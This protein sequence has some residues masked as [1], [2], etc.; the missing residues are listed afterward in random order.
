MP[1][2]FT[3]ALFFNANIKKFIYQNGETYIH[4]TNFDQL[5]KGVGYTTL[6]LSTGYLTYR[7]WTDS[8]AL[9]RDIFAYY[10]VG[11]VITNY[12]IAYKLQK[13]ASSKHHEYCGIQFHK[14]AMTNG[15]V[16]VKIGQHLA[17]M[18]HVIPDEIVSR[19]KPLQADCT[20]RSVEEVLQVMREE[21][22]AER[23]SRFTEFNAIPEGTASIAQVHKATLDG[24]LVA[25][26]I[27][28]R[29]ISSN[30]A[31][32][33]KLLTKLSDVSKVIFGKQFNFQWLVDEVRELLDT[34]L[35]FR[36]EASNATEARQNHA[37][38]PWLVIP[39]IHQEYTTRRILVLNY[40]SGHPIDDPDWYKEND[41][42][43][44][45]VLNKLSYLFSEMTFVTGFLHSDPHP[46]NLKIRKMGPIGPWQIVLLDHGQYRRLN[47]IF[48]NDY[49]HFLYAM[50][51]GNKPNVIKYGKRLNLKDPTA[52]SYLGCMM[53]GVKWE[54]VQGGGLMVKGRSTQGNW[55]E[56]GATDDLLDK[57]L[58]KAMEILNDIPPELTMIMKSN[59]L[60]RCLEHKLTSGNSPE[61]YV[62][63]AHLCI[64]GM[65]SVELS[66]AS[67][68]DQRVEIHSKY[69]WP[70]T[71]IYWYQTYYSVL[72][73]VVMRYN[74][75]VKYYNRFF[76]RFKTVGLIKS[77]E[78]KF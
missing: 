65:L 43:A 76:G 8:H 33:I 7:G 35:D 10:I 47:S 67:N 19:L 37:H 78:D 4:K 22:G 30:A 64:K 29:D 54:N 62:N 74:R 72:G 44:V 1:I 38:F 66:N 24:E 69:F 55:G 31:A 20:Q 59:D 15:G 2:R 23:V 6:T 3:R 58:D 14:L 11:K 42:D 68:Q 61:N 9:R 34:E 41:I 49:C 52:A 45:K 36:N 27:Q 50:V 73:M 26:K 32:D 46:G 70:L 71:R 39:K 60:I 25:I 40:E 12:M 51:N 16:F 63:M 48:K 57:Y 18:A 17:A 13:E 5:A 75:Y 77:A 21:L 53:L 56:K 28:H